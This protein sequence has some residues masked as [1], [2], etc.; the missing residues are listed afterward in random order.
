MRTNLAIALVRIY[1]GAALLLTGLRKLTGGWLSA[2]GDG[3]KWKLQENLEGQLPEL[4]KVEWLGWYHDLVRDSFLPNA[5][6]FTYLVVFGEI[7]IGAAFV[8]G[9]LTRTAA[10]FGILMGTTFFLLGMRSGS[11]LDQIGFSSGPSTLIFLCVLILIADAGR[12]FG[13]DGKLRG[14]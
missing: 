5:A 6:V 1:A 11:L 10:L 9:F 13:L 3:G 12:S 14:A 4:A 2:P 8:M 7:L